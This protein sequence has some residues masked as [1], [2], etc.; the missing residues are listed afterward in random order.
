MLIIKISFRKS[1][2][3]QMMSCLLCDSVVL[4]ILSLNIIKAEQTIRIKDLEDT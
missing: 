2:I 4:I 3:M 1:M